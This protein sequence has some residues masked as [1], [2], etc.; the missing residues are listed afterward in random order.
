M[1]NYYY[2]KIHIF[3]HAFVY[4]NPLTSTK[5]NRLIKFSFV[6]FL[7]EVLKKHSL[8]IKSNL[9]LRHNK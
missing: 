7:S 6:G 1:I 2:T 5:A 9:F 4:K 8:V 3:I